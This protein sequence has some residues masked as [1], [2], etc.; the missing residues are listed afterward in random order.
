[1]I[2][3]R[4]KKE[5]PAIVSRILKL[6]LYSK[7]LL[8]GLMREII[9][10]L[11]NSTLLTA[12]A[13]T[14]I[15]SGI[16]HEHEKFNGWMAAF[17]GCSTWGMYL[18]HRLIKVHNGTISDPRLKH[19]LIRNFRFL[20]F[21]LV[22]LFLSV[23]LLLFFLKLTTVQWSYLMFFSFISIWYVIPVGGNAVRNIPYIKSPIV[24]LTWSLH[25]F[26]FP[27]FFEE[28]VKNNWLE[29][30]NWVLFFYAITIP[31]DSRDSEKDSV[32]M[33]TLPQIVGKK[34]AGI[35]AL[36]LIA[37]FG[38]IALLVNN[39]IGNNFMFWSVILV[40]TF[41]LY[42]FRQS[43]SYIAYAIF[44]LLMILL[45]SSYFIN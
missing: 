36:L 29:I 18:L 7:Q 11:T 45:G 10:F 30:V 24:A 37:V 4:V 21:F 38:V 33:K 44:D 27:L 42:R 39:K 17:I 15:Y 1:M 43:K 20:S 16:A 31:F 2:A 9:L 22:L 35:V 3:Q 19:W 40:L 23:V 32:Q 14:A 26:Y 34:N 25:L 8:T 13:A 6:T 41:T 5:N 28:P 12:I